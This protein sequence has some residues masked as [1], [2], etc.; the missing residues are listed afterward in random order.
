MEPLPDLPPTPRYPC[1]FVTASDIE[2]YLSPHLYA[3]GWGISSLRPSDQKITPP[4]T[5]LSK[6][7]LFPNSD[8]AEIFMKDVNTTIVDR[9]NHHP[10][11]EVKDSDDSSE[12]IV[13]IHV[14]THSA[15]APADNQSHNDAEVFPR[16]RPGITL[17]DI[18]FALLYEELL[19]DYTRQRL[20]NTQTSSFY[21]Q[22]KE[23]GSIHN[24]QPQSQKDSDEA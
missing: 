9:E 18:R 16:K 20:I 4:V 14:H 1:P 24:I 3:A 8:I 17:R 7:V 5:Q 2:K 19:R 23:I 13:T 6:R 22:P 11:W 10:T 21:L 12:H 15:L